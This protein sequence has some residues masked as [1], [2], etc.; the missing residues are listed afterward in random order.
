MKNRATCIQTKP[1]STEEMQTPLESINL[2]TEQSGETM[3]ID[4]VRPLP[5]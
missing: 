3:M 5:N 4:L 1:P 2:E